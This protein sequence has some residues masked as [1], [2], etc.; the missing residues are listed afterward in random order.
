MDET[1]Q[2]LVPE[3]FLA[4]YTGADGRRL[5]APR[6]EVAV[7]YELC[8]DLAQMLAPQ[9][10]ER[11]FALGVDPSDVLRK[12]GDG[13]RGEG[14]PVTPAEAQWVLRR[15]AEVLGWRDPGAGAPA[16]PAGVSRY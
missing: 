10:A 2:I 8:E 15:L 16:D 9:A 14:T 7:R 11:Q 5:T 1:N 6:D 3:S 13:L 4:L 12:F